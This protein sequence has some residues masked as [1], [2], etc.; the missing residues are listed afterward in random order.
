M[1]YLND[2]A[3]D[4]AAYAKETENGQMSNLVAI[5]YYLRLVFEL[6]YHGPMDKYY[7]EKTT[8]S[9]EFMTQSTFG[10]CILYSR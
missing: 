9:I 8:I 5:R 3:L 6:C 1:D 10:L 4:Q 7:I 2:R